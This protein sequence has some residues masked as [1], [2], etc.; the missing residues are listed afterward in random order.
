MKFAV[1]MKVIVIYSEYL[2]RSQCENSVRGE[3]VDTILHPDKSPLSISDEPIVTLKHPPPL[4]HPCQNAEIKVYC[5]G[6]HYVTQNVHCSQF[7]MV[8]AYEFTN[9]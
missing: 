7:L 6:S 2:K 5:N 9:Y 1:G 3:I 4:I 8:G